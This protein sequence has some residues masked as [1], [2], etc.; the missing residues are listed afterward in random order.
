MIM[1]SDNLALLFMCMTFSFFFI[2]FGVSTFK[3]DI[4]D[5][6]PHYLVESMTYVLRISTFTTGQY[7]KYVYP[8]TAQHVSQWC[9]EEFI[10][11]ICS[12]FS[13][14]SPFSLSSLFTQLYQP[15]K[16]FYPLYPLQPFQ[17]C[18][19]FSTSFAFLTIFWPSKFFKYT[20]HHLKNFENGLN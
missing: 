3:T 18:L 15:F 10:T 6:F 13:S 7:A 11:S 2:I 1:S 5:Y 17:I 16:P 20:T 12:L 14:F 4:V 9:S 8:K 19:D